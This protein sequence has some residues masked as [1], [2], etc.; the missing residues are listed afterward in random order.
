VDYYHDC[1]N[2]FFSLD[3]II[4]YFID[5]ISG[6]LLKYYRGIIYLDVNRKIN[7]FFVLCV[8]IYV[9]SFIWEI[10]IYCGYFIAFYKCL[11]FINVLKW[12]FS[13]FF[14]YWDCIVLS[15]IINAFKSW[16]FYRWYN[17]SI[18]ILTILQP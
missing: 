11:N 4:K 9:S 12:F 7:N 16:H 6:L 8:Y 3:I 1:Q 15:T 17:K 10:H 14:L 2:V 13:N 5:S 18:V